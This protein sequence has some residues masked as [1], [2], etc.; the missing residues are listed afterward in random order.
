MDGWRDSTKRQ[1]KVYIEK[2]IDFCG[3]NTIQALEATLPETLTFLTELFHSGVGYSA[4]NTA[5]SALSAILPSLQLGSN[6]ITKK[7]MRGV[8]NRRPSLPKISSIWDVKCVFDLFR[9]P[10]WDIENLQLK[11]LTQKLAVLLI[12]SACERVQFLASL[13]LSNMV[14]NDDGSFDFQINVLLKTSKPGNHKSVVKFR[15][16]QESSL[17]PATHLARYIRMTSYP[18]RNDALFL[19]YRKPHTAASKSSISRWIKEVLFLAGID[20]SVYGAHSTRSASTSHL[21]A[22]GID[23]DQ[24]IKYVGWTNAK[25]FARF[26]NK[27]IESGQQLS[28]F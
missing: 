15:P 21:K 3:R 11:T 23:V 22:R 14:H 4:I 18:N 26:Y 7:F 28:V 16:F 9:L 24:I 5:R 25:T 6:H 10:A 8:F 17:C 12:L 20:I 27:P 2:W 1:Y 19:T 13:S